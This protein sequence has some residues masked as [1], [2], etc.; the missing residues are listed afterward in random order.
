MFVQRAF[1]QLPAESRLYKG[2]VVAPHVPRTEAG[3]Y[4]GYTV[5]LASCLSKRPSL[6]HLNVPRVIFMLVEESLCNY[7]TCGCYCLFLQVQ[8]SHKVHIKKDMI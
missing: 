6:S 7:F 5:R 3:L 1:V 4:W 8:F 2:V